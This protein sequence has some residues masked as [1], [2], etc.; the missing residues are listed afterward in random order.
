MCAEP[1]AAQTTHETAH[2][3]TGVG[4]D[5]PPQ[6]R[7]LFDRI[8]YVEDAEGTASLHLPFPF[9]ALVAQ[10]RQRLALD[11][12]PDALQTVLIPLGRSLQRNAAAPDFFRSPRVVLA[13]LGESAQQSAPLAKDRLYL[14][15]QEQAGVIEAISYNAV[16]GR[17]EFQ[18]VKGYQA[19]SRP[20]LFYAKRIICMACH[21]NQAPIFSRPLWSETHANPR[22]AARLRA[23]RADVYGAELA[24]GIDVP[25]AIDAAT[26]RANRYALEQRL[27][28]E[29]CASLAS[30]MEQTD[31]ATQ[32]RVAL[33][34]AVLKLRLS[35]WRGFVGGAADRLATLRAHWQAQ[36]PAGWP[37]PN[38]DIPNRDPFARVEP[39][40]LRAIPVPA[41]VDPLLLRQPL[42]RL[43]FA[44]SGALR[45]L[46]QGLANMFTQADIAALDALLFAAQAVPIREWRVQCR[47]RR[48][49]VGQL[50]EQTAWRLDLHCDPKVAANA[51][52]GLDGRLY[53]RGH[54]LERGVLDRLRIGVEGFTDVS[55]TADAELSAGRWVLTPRLNG[56]HARRETGHALAALT[57]QLPGEAASG[58]V[59]GEMSGAEHDATL[60]LTERQDYTLLDA[61]LRAL[62]ATAR[63]ASPFDAQPLRRERVLSAV[64]AQLGQAAPD[65]CCDAEAFPPAQREAYS[66]APARAESTFDP[67]FSTM[68][69]ILERYCM[70]CHASAESFPPNF[71]S[72]DAEQV[73]A[74]LTQCAERIDDRTRMWELDAST[75]AK[76]PMPPALLVPV[77]ARLQDD[78]DWR[79]LRAYVGALRA[80]RPVRATQDY[81]Q[82]EP[83]LTAGGR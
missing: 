65:F 15:Y 28:R 38:P 30:T 58:E 19:Q 25:D 1:A 12:Q 20:R 60:I 55:I 6:G 21:Q 43:D 10:L 13:V 71:L 27:W 39:A 50:S 56:L 78:P 79:R 23:V 9:A 11:A 37:V 31:T 22:V 74:K 59:P 8:A 34:D 62:A 73:R 52:I 40:P 54:R 26:D 24:H 70:A 17:F 66:P 36:W 81:E 77:P 63:G 69:P 44:D 18:I 3:T 57:L 2:A 7:S 76:S 45:G 14:G 80:A 51:G 32:C 68:L 82:L 46:I 83:C 4:A 5:I 33:L 64:Y 75:R 49:S 72:G 35:G 16:L 61:A 41:A 67:A 42:G 48:Q 29:A 47:V 53:F